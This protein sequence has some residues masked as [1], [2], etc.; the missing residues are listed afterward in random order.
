MENCSFSWGFRVKEV[1]GKTAIRGFVETEKENRPVLEDVNLKI[2][3]KGLITV[4]GQ[5]GCGKTTLLFSIME[6]THRL[7]GQ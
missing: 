5:V 4:V 3:G 2:I 1:Q 6:E 7:S